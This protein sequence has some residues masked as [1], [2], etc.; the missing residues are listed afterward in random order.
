MQQGLFH[1]FSNIVI[2]N[3][4][5]LVIKYKGYLMEWKEYEAKKRF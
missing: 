2:F 4:H 3:N 1:F 5:K